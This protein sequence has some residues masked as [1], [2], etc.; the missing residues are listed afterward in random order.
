MAIPSPAKPE[1]TTATRTSA[2]GP[3]TGRAG[4]WA[5]SGPRSGLTR[6]TL[7]PARA[8]FGGPRCPEPRQRADTTVLNDD[9]VRP[10]GSGR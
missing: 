5:G 8:E 1:P 7:Q 2:T 9:V 4:E 10:L 3:F 6:G